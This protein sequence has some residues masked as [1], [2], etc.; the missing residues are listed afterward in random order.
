MEQTQGASAGSVPGLLYSAINCSSSVGSGFHSGL[1]AGSSNGRTGYRLASSGPC[2][3]ARGSGSQALLEGSRHTAHGIIATAFGL[4]TVLFGA[5]G[6][7]IELRDA[8]NTIWEVPTP[9]L[10]GL[11]KLS[12]FIKERLFSFALVLAIGFIMVVSLALSA[13]VAALGAWSAS[14]LP[15]H[16]AILHILNFVVSFGII[17]G[18]FSAIYKFLPGVRIEWRDVVLGGAVTALLFTVGKLALGIYLG[19]ASFASTYGAA[20]SIVVLIVWVYYSGQIFFL[21][22]EFTKTFANSYGSQPSRKPDGL[23]IDS[24]TNRKMSGAL[25]ENAGWDEDALSLELQQLSEAEFHLDLTD[26]LR[27]RST[28]CSLF[29]TRSGLMPCRRFLRILSPD[30][31]HLALR[32]TS[33]ALW[34][35][36]ELG[37]RS[38]PA[39]RPQAAA[40]GY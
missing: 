10:S 13:W 1:G 8:L 36:H 21:G 22:A 31:R 17:T 3:E 34:R 25:T 19:K 12:S 30:G 40:D 20:A 35:C 27:V 5:S 6:V 16:E 32:K 2:R 38:A 9:E 28:R 11:K 14:I 33:G 7:L 26:S 18:L 24:A 29:L 4:L 37:R 39:W 15:A 23:V